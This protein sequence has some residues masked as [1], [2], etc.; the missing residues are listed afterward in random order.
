MLRYTITAHAGGAGPTGLGAPAARPAGL[1][2]R[3]DEL[4]VR[5]ERPSPADGTA[6]GRNDRIQP[7]ASTRNGFAGEAACRASD[8]RAQGTEEV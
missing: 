6:A 5:A 4:C 7:P 2:A 8:G 3:A 1:L